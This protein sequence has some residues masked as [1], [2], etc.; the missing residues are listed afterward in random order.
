MI[1]RAYISRG[2]APTMLQHVPVTIPDDPPAGAHTW[3][4]V[5]SFTGGGGARNVRSR[6]LAVREMKTEA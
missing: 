5:C 3:D 2:N 6:L 4:L 1:L